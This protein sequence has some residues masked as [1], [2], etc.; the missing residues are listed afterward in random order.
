MQNALGAGIWDFDLAENRG[1]PVLALE[2][3]VKGAQ[4]EITIVADESFR[5]HPSPITFDDM[6]MGEHYDANLEIDGWNLPGFDDSD[7]KNAMKAETPR[8]KLKQCSA[9]PILKSGEMKP[10]RVIKNKNGFIYDLILVEHARDFITCKLNI[11][12]IRCSVNFIPSSC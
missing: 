10:V 5:V 7:W 6:R 12:Y 3:L 8:G 2:L 4:D 1:A 11:N 9:E